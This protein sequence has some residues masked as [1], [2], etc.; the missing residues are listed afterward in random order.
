MSNA[1]G[2]LHFIFHLTFFPS[3]LPFTS[4]SSLLH[5]VSHLLF[6]FLLLCFMLSVIWWVAKWFD[7][8]NDSSWC[9]FLF[10]CRDKWYT[11]YLSRMGFF[12]A[13]AGAVV[14]VIK[15]MGVSVCWKMNYYWYVFLAL[16]GVFTFAYIKTNITPAYAWR[17]KWTQ[18]MNRTNARLVFTFFIAPSSCLN[19]CIC[20]LNKLKCVTKTWLQDYICPFFIPPPLPLYPVLVRHVLLILFVMFATKCYHIVELI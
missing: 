9:C 6:F 19:I 11:P 14:V 17:L 20:V 7:Y 12:S 3:P 18:K 5:H 1:S 16:S 8:F 15:L 4:S 13:L 2:T 10:G